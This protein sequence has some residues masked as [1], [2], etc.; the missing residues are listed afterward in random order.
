[1]R[2]PPAVA[3]CRAAV[4]GALVDLDGGALVLAACSGGPDS[5]ALTAALVTQAPRLGLRA[6]VLTVDHGLQPGSSDRAGAVADWARRSGADPVEV[7]RVTVGAVGGPEAAARTARYAALE[8]A[9]DRLGAAVVL[10]G[11]TRDDQAETVLLGLARGSGTRS[12]AGMAPRNGRYRRPFLDIARATTVAAAA[13]E[14]LPVWDDPHNSDPA[15]TR[16]R[17]RT[18]ALPTL[19]RTLGPGVAAALARTAGLLRDDADALDLWAERAARAATGSDGSLLVAALVGLPA[20]VRRRVLLAAA[21]T[22]GCPAGALTARH[23]RGLDDLITGAGPGRAAASPSRTVSLAGGYAARLCHGRLL[24]DRAGTP[25]GRAQ[26]LP[27][28]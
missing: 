4:R 3:D 1:M 23:V 24:F 15:Y 8:E 10:V 5:A 17:V 22:A 26:E 6:G 11:H 25:A 14:R 28:G 2:L 27:G 19:E 16:V 7:L 21:R 12:L 13:A 20:A 9:A 18:A